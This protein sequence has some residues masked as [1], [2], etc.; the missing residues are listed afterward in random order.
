MQHVTA[1]A[2]KYAVYHGPNGERAP[3]RVAAWRAAA[4]A[5]QEGAVEV[6]VHA[7]EVEV[8]GEGFEEVEGVEV[9]AEPARTVEP[10]ART[11]GGGAL[12]GGTLGGGN[13]VGQA[14]DVP[15]AE[16]QVEP[17]PYPNP[18]PNPNPSPNP[19]PSPNPNPNPNP[20]PNLIQT[21]TL[22]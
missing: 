1:N 12:G 3:S 7:V 10:A 19:S 8:E 9:E 17:Y 4:R 5:N 15:M 14:V 20:K 22:T 2:R 18:T 11:L 6:E 13:W 16:F 21:L